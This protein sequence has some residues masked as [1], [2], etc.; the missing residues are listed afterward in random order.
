MFC[1]IFSYFLCNAGDHF[2]FGQIGQVAH[3]S[4]RCIFLEKYVELFE[5]FHVFK[6]VAWIL[7]SLLLI[8]PMEWDALRP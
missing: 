7:A 3:I 4:R 2:I 5:E 6:E 8:M 1:D